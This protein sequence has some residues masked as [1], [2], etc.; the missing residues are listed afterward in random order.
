MVFDLE[1]TEKGGSFEPDFSDNN[2]QQELQYQDVF[3]G[4]KGDA[5]A[6]GKDGISP[7]VSIIKAAG[8]TTVII[9]DAQGSHSAVILDGERGA[10]G[11]DGKDGK[12]GIN[13]KDGEK[14]EQGIQG[15]QG[16]RGEKGETGAAGKDGINGI[17]GVNGKDGADGKD[18]YTPI[19]YV[20]YYTEA[21]RAALVN[22]IVSRVGGLEYVF[23]SEAQVDASGKPNFT[24]AANKFYFVPDPNGASPNLFT[25]WL[26]TAQGWEIVG[27]SKMN[28]DGYATESWV[29][30]QGFLKS[31]TE[32]DPT[33][34]QWAK[35]TNKPTYTAA[36]VGALPDTTVIPTVPKNVSAFTNDSGYLTQHQSLDGYAKTA[37]IPTDTHINE[38]IS[39]QLG[40]IENGT[41]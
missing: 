39:A 25:E 41:Y 12:D 35:A 15:E 31:F 1:Y 29:N 34:P 11:K 36:E 33:V 8:A 27:G 23:L 7:T 26:Y 20:D 6:D 4:E 30:G 9:T 5:G 40:V 10:D 3:K 32:S 21:E 24:G 19:K 17:N 18:G 22:E 14:G 16:L 38:L 28:L 2:S 13:G 37:D